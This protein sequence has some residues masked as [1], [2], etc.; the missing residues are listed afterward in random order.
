LQKKVDV[1]LQLSSKGVKVLR[2]N[3]KAWTNHG[4]DLRTV[5][6]KRTFNFP[7]YKPPK[8]SPHNW[9][10]NFKFDRPFVRVGA[11]LAV[12]FKG[13]VSVT[14]SNYWYADCKFLGFDRGLVLPFKAGCPSS[15]SQFG[16]NLYVGAPGVAYTVGNSLAAGELISWGGATKLQ[17]RIPGTSCILFTPLTLVHPIP[18]KTSDRFG[19]ARFT[20]GKIPSSLAGK[21]LYFQIGGIGKA[22]LKLSKGLQIRMGAG[23]SGGVGDFWHSGTDNL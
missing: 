3:L 1:E 11:D 22:G 19:T 23:V 16:F 5:I 4:V 20:W 14:D 8:A 17:I 6:K 2:P 7:A 9:N 10:L 18:V 15:F 12:D 13:F 21:T